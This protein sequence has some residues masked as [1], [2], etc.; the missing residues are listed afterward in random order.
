[1]AVKQPVSRVVRAELHHHVPSL[2]YDEGV[3][4]NCASV[5]GKSR[6]GSRP[7]TRAR[8]TNRV[9]NISIISVLCAGEIS[10]AAEQG[11]IF[12]AVLSVAIFEDVYI[13]SVRGC[14]WDE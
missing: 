10:R 7:E 13:P 2:W 1:M 14:V 11:A 8:T 6:V 9:E 12:T 3:F 5:E 4:P